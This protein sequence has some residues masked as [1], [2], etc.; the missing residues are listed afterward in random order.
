MTAG[1][2]VVRISSFHHVFSRRLYPSGKVKAIAPTVCGEEIR[3]MRDSLGILSVLIIRPNYDHKLRR[4]R[5][6]GPSS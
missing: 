6:G 2:V 4:L 5:L 1:F 3:Y